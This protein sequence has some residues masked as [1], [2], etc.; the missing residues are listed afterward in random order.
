[1]YLLSRIGDIGGEGLTRI[2][3]GSRLDFPLCL[4]N[5]MR[6]NGDRNASEF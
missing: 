3:P 6:P 1:M 4:S 5:K 2:D